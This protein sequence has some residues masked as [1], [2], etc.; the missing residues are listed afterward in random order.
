MDDRGGV[1]QHIEHARCR[2]SFKDP[3]PGAGPCR[4]G[5]KGWIPPN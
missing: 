5:G 2:F 1:L 4:G 3:K